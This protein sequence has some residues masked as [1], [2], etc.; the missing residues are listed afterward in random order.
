MEWVGTEPTVVG[1]FRNRFFPHLVH[2]EKRPHTLLT[3]PVSFWNKTRENVLHLSH[4]K[5]CILVHW[6][7]IDKKLK[8][9]KFARVTIKLFSIFQLNS[10]ILSV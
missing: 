5:F 10:I 8:S 4:E 6:L 2:P 3:V 9:S 7:P 1:P